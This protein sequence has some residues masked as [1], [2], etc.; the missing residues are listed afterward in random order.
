MLSGDVHPKPLEVNR[1]LNP[2]LCN[3]STDWSQIILPLASVLSGFP[4]TSMHH[5][6]KNT[7]SLGAKPLSPHEEM[8][9]RIKLDTE[10]RWFTTCVD[11]QVSETNLQLR[12]SRGMRNS[13]KAS[14]SSTYTRKLGSWQHWGEAKSL[15]QV[16]WIITWQV[17][18]TLQE[19]RALR[20]RSPSAM[21]LECPLSRYGGSRA[22]HRSSGFTE[23]C[24]F[25]LKIT[26]S[27]SHNKV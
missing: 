22:L 25:P 9:S 6:H 7:F 10:L 1:R 14:K 8:S 13:C 2:S 20:L 11:P 15:I 23:W 16:V 4:L 27:L 18:P 19:A 5:K 21:S 3:W 24:A 17:P 26:F 12:N